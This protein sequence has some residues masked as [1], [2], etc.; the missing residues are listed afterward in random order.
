MASADPTPPNAAPVGEDPGVLRLHLI[1]TAAT[2][3]GQA[4]WW[5]LP[6]LARHR[7][8]ANDWQTLALT[9]AVP[10]AQFFTI[11]WN[12]LY[13]RV[14]IRAYLALA[15]GMTVIPIA[16]MAAATNVWMVMGCFAIAAFGGVGGGAALSPLNADMLRACYAA[17]R[18]GR[19]FG[20]VS[21]A[22][23]MAVMITGQAIGWWSD[24]DR[25]AFRVFLPILAGLNL[26]GLLMFERVSR[27]P[28]FR[29]RSLLQVEA[30]RTWWEPLRDMGRIL[31]RD[32]RF[33]GYEIAFMSY[34]TGFMICTAL[35]PFL[36]TDELKLNNA[37]YTFVTVVVFQCTMMLLF[38]PAGRLAD[39]IGPA[40][41]ASGSF[42]WLTFYP[43]SLIACSSMGMLGVSTFLFALG[44]AGVHLTWTL[45]PVS[46]APDPSRAPLY[47]AIHGTLVGIRGI[48]AQGL[49]VAL[50]A[51]TGGFVV[52]FA[53]AAAAF[54]YGG[55]RMRRLARDSAV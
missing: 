43:L 7:F 50:L 13:A 35:L 1:G 37:G 40:R 47:L 10:V 26:L 24:A 11:Y 15:A 34:G 53:L 20:W 38:V 52:P 49:G 32:R 21:A 46:L 48:V 23:M 6:F 2:G 22:G 3:A 4:L 9:A 45:G 28:V 5:F 16:T 8:D 27:R 31:R 14:S 25:D 30:T 51:L 42:F 54:C 18:R 12:H 36:G 33:A 55:W 17:K 44:M 39:R 19:A 41:L 29:Q